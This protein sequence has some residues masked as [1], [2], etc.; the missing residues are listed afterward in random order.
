MGFWTLQC[1]TQAQYREEVYRHAV[2]G[3]AGAHNGQAKIT[4][5]LKDKA[6]VGS[7]LFGSEPL[8]NRSPA[9]RSGPRGREH[10]DSMTISLSYPLDFAKQAQVRKIKALVHDLATEQKEKGTRGKSLKQ[11][12]KGMVFKASEVR[13][14]KEKEKAEKQA[15]AEKEKASK[16]K[17]KQRTRATADT[18]KKLKAQTQALKKQLRDSKAQIKQLKKEKQLLQSQR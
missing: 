17:Q 6:D 13:E 1:L 4:I 15:K 7:S 3:H 18:I 2:G 9:G 12:W 10:P 5:R 11:G 16:E 8:Y 14:Q